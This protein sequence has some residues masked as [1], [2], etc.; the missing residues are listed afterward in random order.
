MMI[1]PTFVG[2]ERASLRG[3][4]HCYRHRD[5]KTN[6]EPGQN[7][8]ESLLQESVTCYSITSLAEHQHV[9]VRIEH[10]HLRVAV[11]LAVGGADDRHF[12]A[13]GFIELAQA[14][15]G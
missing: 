14:G 6:C 15:D 5:E 9:L 3:Q 13:H 8:H 2:L 12:G 10:F 11:R 1:E 7:T 4:R